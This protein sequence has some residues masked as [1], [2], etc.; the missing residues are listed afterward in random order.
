MPETRPPVHGPVVDDQTR[1]IHYATELDVIAIRFACCGQ[2]YP[3]H[4]CHAESADH[5]A[6]AWPRS[7]YAE[8]AVLCGVCGSELTIEH[9]L[10]VDGCPNCGA[11]FNPG[12][13]LH[14]HLY[15]E[16]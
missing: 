12:C 15:F 8:R 1:C 7:S 9:Y 11:A 13:R 14:S 16:A 6:V 3:C 5:P 10:A 2:Y 4:L